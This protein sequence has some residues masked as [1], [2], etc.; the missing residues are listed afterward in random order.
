MPLRVPGT[1]IT[2]CPN[3]GASVGGPRGVHYHSLSAWCLNCGWGSN[4]DR[5]PAAQP[6]P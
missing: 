6:Q 2:E 1:D 4:L 3:C 5:L